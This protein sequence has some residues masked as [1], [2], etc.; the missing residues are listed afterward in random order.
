M[1]KISGLVAKLGIT[2]DPKKAAALAEAPPRLDS[3]AKADAPEATGAETPEATVAA[4]AEPSPPALL[5]PSNELQAVSLAL[6]KRSPYQVRAM[7]DEN[8]ID[9]L[10]T[11]IQESGVISPI[12][13]RLIDGGYEFVA[14]EHRALACQKLGHTTIL[15]LVRD[16]TDQQAAIA[17]ASDNAVRKELTAYDRY[18]HL[19]MLKQNGFV[20][21]SREAAAVLKISPSGVSQLNSFDDLPEAALKLLANNP[22]KFGADALYEIRPW[23]RLKPELVT[24]AMYRVL[25]KKLEQSQ[26]ADWLEHECTP[27][28]PRPSIRVDTREIILGRQKIKVSA[29]SKTA[30]IAI[31]GLNADKLAALIE[32]NLDDLLTK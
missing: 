15:A 26:M 28:V 23:A 29:T 6:I 5:H 31:G 14:G 9:E 21:T 7:G 13:V 19:Q 12:V 17:L 4:T 25:D 11:S 8:Y 27:H 1:A 3:E 20:K 16:L 22:D 10:A 18:L 32:A 30:K 2:P 24:A